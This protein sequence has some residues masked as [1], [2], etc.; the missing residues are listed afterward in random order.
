MKGQHL[1]V[2]IKLKRLNAS[3]RTREHANCFKNL[4]PIESVK[5]EIQT[6]D[7][8]I[9][10]PCDLFYWHSLSLTIS[11]PFKLITAIGLKSTKQLKITASS[12]LRVGSNRTLIT[13][14]IEKVHIWFKQP[15]KHNT[16]AFLIG[17]RACLDCWNKE[18]E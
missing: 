9:R 7:K 14:E 3:F 18:R 4:T 11:R 2:L 8:G 5:I 17:P 13:T 16:C 15:G 10:F 1:G 6:K 12:L